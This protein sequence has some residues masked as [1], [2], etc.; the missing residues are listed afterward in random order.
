[1]RAIKLKYL[2]SNQKKSSFIK[3]KASS[4]KKSLVNKRDKELGPYKNLIYIIDEY[5]KQIEEIKE[6]L[7]SL[8][9]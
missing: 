9:Y 5:L 7:D 6:Y 1:M 2:D 4:R 3:T 8:D